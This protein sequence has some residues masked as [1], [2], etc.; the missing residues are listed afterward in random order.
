MFVKTIMTNKRFVTK[1]NDKNF[2]K[3]FILKSR[4]EILLRRS[5]ICESKIFDSYLI[6]LKQSYLMR[7]LRQFNVVS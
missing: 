2:I 3:E 1:K 5:L 4:S 6:D 7:R